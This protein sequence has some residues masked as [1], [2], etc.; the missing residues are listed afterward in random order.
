MSYN[1]SILR[2][3]LFLSNNS[4]ER[5]LKN[6]SGKSEDFTKVYDLMFQYLKSN[7]SEYAS[8]LESLKPRSSIDDTE[9]YEALKAEYAKYAKMCDRGLHH[10]KVSIDDYLEELE[11]S[12]VRSPIANIETRIK[13]FD[14]TM[15]KCERR[16][17]PKTIQS[18][19][20][21]V[22]D[23]AGIRIITVFRDDVYEVAEALRSRLRLSVN[24]TKDYI[25]NRKD[26][27]YQS[28]HLIVKREFYFNGES[29]YIP[30]EIQIRTKAMD[31]WATVEHIAKYK[32]PTP[33]PEAE[34]AFR[35]AADFLVAFD[36]IAIKLRDNEDF[37]NED[38]FPESKY[39]K[40]SSRD[41][42]KDD[43][44]SEKKALNSITHKANSAR[45][46]KSTGPARPIKS[47]KPAESAQSTI[48]KLGSKLISSTTTAIN[49]KSKMVL[50]HLV[51][52]LQ[53]KL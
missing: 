35:K 4:K 40:Q 52:Y 5:I 30:V 20:D 34:T 8:E 13:E 37:G 33:S 15:E 3:V 29:H 9:A 21:N 46:A 16:G 12:G 24:V 42:V 28:L 26:N 53:I 19:R 43:D 22:Q 47:T 25:N 45:P 14:S 36:D 11:D 49:A 32:N 44:Y 31:L 18:I 39:M 48:A 1:Y 38:L 10:I 17:Y 23:V 6:S 7:M 41:E 51:D 2:E 27:G 50:R